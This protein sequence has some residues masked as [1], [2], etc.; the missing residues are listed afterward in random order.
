[1]RYLNKTTFLTAYGKFLLLN[2]LVLLL[3]FGTYFQVYASEADAE[4]PSLDTSS[5]VSYTVTGIVNSEQL[6]NL[7][8][9]EIV[10]RSSQ[11]TE[12]LF[13]HI[14][15]NG[16][17]NV[18]AIIEDSEGTISSLALP[19]S[20]SCWND[21]TT[22]TNTTVC[23]EYMETG[24]IQLPDDSYKWGE[25]V[26]SE[27]TLLVKVY[28]P[29]E[30]VEIVKFEEVWN[31]FDTAFSLEQN[32]SIEELLQNDNNTHSLQTYWPCYD[33][34]G[35]EYLC[36]VLYNT[37]NVNADTVGI[38]D[39]TVTFE[40]PL[41]CRFS[42]SLT[43]P[44]Y[45]I[46]VTVQAPGQPRLDLSYISANYEFIIFPWITSGT[47]LDTMEVWMS[48]NN[49]EWRM[50]E[51]D[52]EA[53]IYDIMLN[54]YASLLTEGSSYQIQVKYEGGQTGIASFTYEWDM[55]SDKDYIE[56]DRDGG[57]TDGNPSDDSEE[58]ASDAEDSDEDSN[59]ED[60]GSDVTSPAQTQ[61]PIVPPAS[62]TGLLPVVP[63][64]SHVNT[65]N[66]M[67]HKT[68]KKVSAPTDTVS[69]REEPYVL[70][71]ELNR[72]MQNMGTARFSSETIMLDI[73]EDTIASLGISDTDRI[74]VNILP[75]ESNSFSIDIFVNDIAV[76]ALSSMQ[77]SLPYQPAKNTTPVLINADGT[78]IAEGSYDKSTG[79]VT[80]IIN[81]TGTFYIRDEE[82]PMADTSTGN[83][84]TVTEISTPHKDNGN[85]IFMLIVITATVII[86]STAVSL[87][88][89]IKKGDLDG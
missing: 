83:T 2:L 32:G 11:N 72:M 1:M 41:N 27:L 16:L 13:Y 38:Y 59:F 24:I 73:P 87:F 57:D 60:K 12:P 56:G 44:S 28:D 61:E 54:L 14:F 65:S 79:I 39:I 3:T 33:A 74:L 89:Y 69:D 86:C 75:L 70:G 9:F 80:F 71:S 46:P 45:S 81:K 77:V 64:D 23:G 19:V 62:D 35:N 42:D 49:G 20:W 82:I 63:S 26:L 66:D 47:D 52:W 40:A 84:H 29:V 6:S 48:E 10:R 31:E 5:T 76:T 43:V 30:L 7:T 78:V 67:N 50:L 8:P 55:L 17:L 37:E 25:G 58:D 34:N 4:A 36:P 85:F 22:V 88:I 18:N 68:A 53:Y 51:L 15:N 21:S